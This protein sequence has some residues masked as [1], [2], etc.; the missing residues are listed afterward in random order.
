VELAE[1]LKM[2]SVAG[3]MHIE[4]NNHQ[5]GAIVIATDAARGL[6]IFGCRFRLTLEQHQAKAGDVQI[7]RNHIG[8]KRRIHD[9]ARRAER[10]LKTLFSLSHLVGR[11]SR[12][13]FYRRFDLP[14]CENDVRRFGPAALS[15]IATDAVAHF[16]FDDPPRSTE[17]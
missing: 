8:G 7:Y 17:F 14:I 3:L 6:D 1:L 11:L 12:G 15:A 5:P 2:H 16:V 13:Q 10:G 9:L 4:H